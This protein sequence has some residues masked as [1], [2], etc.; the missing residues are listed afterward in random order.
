MH[1]G[2]AVGGFYFNPILNLAYI[3]IPKCASS[4]IKHQL[5]KLSNMYPDQGIWTE[6]HD[7]N[8]L[9]EDAKKLIVLRETI[10]RWHSGIFEYLYRNNLPRHSEDW[11]FRLLLDGKVFDEHTERQSYFLE[12]F[13]LTK[14][15]IWFP[16]D[17][18][19]TNKWDN[20]ML[21]VGYPINSRTTLRVN[22]RNNFLDL[23]KGTPA[24]EWKMKLVEYMRK[25][26][27]W[28]AL[29]VYYKKDAQML[30][31]FLDI[32]TIMRYK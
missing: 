1:R 27:R 31:S 32:D 7:P 13:D 3:N 24:R 18:T 30:K 25:Q 16:C 10:E 23:P 20:F 4:N 21:G 28:D 17:E 2:H 8:L 11:Y 29:D 9:P 15:T 14:N 12:P 22:H 6:L 19:L 26:H 5:E